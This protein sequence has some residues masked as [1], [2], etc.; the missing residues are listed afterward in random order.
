[1][2]GFIFALTLRQLAL[3][4]STLLLAG[5][6]AIPAL[7]A[8]VFELAAR[9]G[10]PER[11]T[12]RVLCVWLVTTTVLPLTALMVG[13][14][15]LG[16]DLEDGTLVYLLTKPIDRWRILAPKLAAAWLITA[17]LVAASVAV[18]ASVVLA[19]DGARLVFGF[20]VATAVGALAYTA[21]FALLSLLTSRA[22]IGAMIYVFLWEGA[23][24]GVF[25]GVR[26][27]SVRHYTLG[28]AEWL[29]RVPDAQYEATVGG[30]TAFILAAVVVLAA[31]AIANRRL[32]T[33]EIAE[34]P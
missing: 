10:D 8:V 21:L 11:F 6:A 2:M 14:S 13:T 3:R 33:V 26:Y 19:E 16:D 22:L 29:G 34:A 25:E 23:L 28:L 20:C 5:L 9:D 24:A 4:R 32:E 31:S 1:M 12:V 7:V 18:A 17:A 15:V 30:G 27:L